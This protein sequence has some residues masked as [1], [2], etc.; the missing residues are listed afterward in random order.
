MYVER[1]DGNPVRVGHPGAL[2]SSRP[3]VDIGVFDKPAIR[4]ASRLFSRT[5]EAA[6][7]RRPGRQDQQSRPELSVQVDDEI[8]AIA[9]EGRKQPAKTLRGRP[10]SPGAEI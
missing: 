3:A 9:L 5:V 2:A 7:H 8:V 4:C 1:G 10:T 6:P